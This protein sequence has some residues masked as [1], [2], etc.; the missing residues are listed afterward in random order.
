VSTDDACRFVALVREGDR[1]DESVLGEDVQMLACG[2]R[3]YVV[4][5][6]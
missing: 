4:S 5:W 2:R 3:S 1:L 6:V